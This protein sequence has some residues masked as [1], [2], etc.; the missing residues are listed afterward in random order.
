MQK[1]VTYDINE[2]THEETER[3]VEDFTQEWADV[4]EGDLENANWHSALDALAPLIQLLPAIYNQVDEE[5]KEKLT[6]AV[7]KWDSYF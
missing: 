3:E 4:V 5:T 6:E 2:E 7:H 1:R